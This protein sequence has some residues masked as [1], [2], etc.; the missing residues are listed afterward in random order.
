MNI[1]GY[2]DVAQIS[3]KF[4][5]VPRVIFFGYGFWVMHVTHWVLGWYMTL[6]AA[7][8]TLE[9]TGLAGSIITVI[10]GLFPWF[11]KIYSD[12]SNDW[13]PPT[14]SVKTQLTTTSTE[15]K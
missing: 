7:E 4:R 6:P 9:A 3:D 2:L 15:I 1:Q 11:Y 12:N 8:R 5:L 10:T 14:S 13:A